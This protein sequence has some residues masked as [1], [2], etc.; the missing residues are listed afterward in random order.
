MK[1]ISDC[2]CCYLNIYI[3]IFIF[4][5]ICIINFFFHEYIRNII[6]IIIA[7]L[8]INLGSIFFFD[9]SK[10]RIIQVVVVA[11]AV[12]NFGQK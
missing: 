4:M 6:I 5:C 3:Y 12:H 8:E 10:R 7:K 2:F 1:K 11:L 9:G